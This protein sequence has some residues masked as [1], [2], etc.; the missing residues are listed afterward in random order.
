MVTG[1][2]T[3][4]GSRNT[5]LA[6]LTGHFHSNTHTQC[7]GVKPP[8]CQGSLSPSLPSPPLPSTSL[9]LSPLTLPL[10]IPTYLTILSQLVRELFVLFCQ[11]QLEAPVSSNHQEPGRLQ[12]GDGGGGRSNFD[13]EFKIVDPRSAVQGWWSTWINSSYAHLV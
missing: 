10:P 2:H 3:Q 4:E 12:E 7:K 5:P 11:S 9:P 1:G 8:H 6:L 13:S